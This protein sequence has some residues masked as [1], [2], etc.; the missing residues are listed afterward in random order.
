MD[1]SKYPRVKKFLDLHPE[2]D[3]DQLYEW[4]EKELHRKKLE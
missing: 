1:L 3:L 4:T 2:W